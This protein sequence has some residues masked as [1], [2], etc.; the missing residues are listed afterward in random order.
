MSAD[1]IASGQALAPLGSVPQP[2]EGTAPTRRASRWRKFAVKVPWLVAATVIVAFVGVAA[3][4][5][6]APTPNVWTD[7]A[8]L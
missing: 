3:L 8:Y 7:D 2:R 1:T 5:I 4:R 6:Y